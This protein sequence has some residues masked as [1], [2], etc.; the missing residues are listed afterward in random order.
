MGAPSLKAAKRPG[1]PLPAFACAAAAIPFGWAFQPSPVD[2]KAPSVSYCYRSVCHRVKTVEQTR[3]LIGRL[4]VVETSYYDLPGVDRFNTGIYT[5]NGERFD[6][7]DQA[8]VASADLPD[9]TELLLRNPINGRVS[10]VRVNDFGPF[11][12]D[13][14]LDVTRRVAED[15]DF[16]HKGVVR[17]EVIVIAAPADDD[18]TYRRNRERRAT[19]G[20][21]GVVFEPEMPALISGLIAERNPAAEAGRA[22]AAVEK[23]VDEIPVPG[24]GPAADMVASADPVVASA[25]ADFERLV[26][27]SSGEPQTEAVNSGMVGLTIAQFSGEVEAQPSREAAAEL[28][29]SP[30]DQNATSPSLRTAAYLS[31][32]ETPD[33][34]DAQTTADATTSAPPAMRAESES[35]A[36][37]T[38]ATSD[39][40]GALS[41][42]TTSRNLL[43]VILAGLLSA[44]LAAALSTGHR[45][46]RRTASAHQRGAMG[47][48]QQSGSRGA[49][50]PPGRIGERSSLCQ[51]VVTDNQRVR[52][53]DPTGRRR[54]ISCGLLHRSGLRHRRPAPLD[55]LHRSRRQDQGPDRGGRADR[56]GGW[57]RRWRG[58]LSR[59]GSRRHDNRND[60][61]PRA[62]RSRYRPRRRGD[63]NRRHDGRAGCIVRGPGAPPAF[64][65]G[66]DFPIAPRMA[67]SDE[68]RSRARQTS[69]ADSDHAREFPTAQVVSI[70]G[71]D[72]LYTRSR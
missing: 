15:L 12:G 65:V 23:S 51:R 33:E 13:R 56:S 10:H 38:V 39:F 24:T 36:R 7:N 58:D 18:L 22:I 44:T 69:G 1:L 31:A 29:P 71:T 8:R 53:G 64:R 52:S 16:K 28:T 61:H 55:R 54:G 19:R 27:G 72:P 20:H 5:S 70:D 41:L 4:L 42:P 3:R 17:L 62:S 48:S 6:A 30:A 67:V 43:L 57:R 2:A 46:S 14:R 34:A 66:R 59:L 35:L 68:L 37:A 32:P 50:A 47:N 60:L 49:E 11:R 21:L 9:G 63:R 45:M 40:S 25:N 26:D